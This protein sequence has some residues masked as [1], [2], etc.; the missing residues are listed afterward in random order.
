MSRT[1]FNTELHTES[2]TFAPAD[3]RTR[4]LTGDSKE[5]H[6]GV[7]T[8]FCMVLPI[9]LLFIFGIQALVTHARYLGVPNFRLTP[10]FLTPYLYS[11]QP[12]ILTSC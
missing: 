6:T 10:T 9:D 5:F 11:L 7:H 4:F 8:E 3:I 12:G 1:E 2:R